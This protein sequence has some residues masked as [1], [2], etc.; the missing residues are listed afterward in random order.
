MTKP[1]KMIGMCIAVLI[2]AMAL[3]LLAISIYATN[4]DAPIR[5]SVQQGTVEAL[6]PQY[7]SLIHI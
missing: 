3:Q 2:V 5:S 4:S 7:L 6:E 1:R